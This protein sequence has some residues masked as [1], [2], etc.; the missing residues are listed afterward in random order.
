LVRYWA[1]HQPEEASRWA[2]TE[3]P[4]VYRAAA[5]YSALSVW[6]EANP[7]VAVDRTWRWGGFPDLQLIVPIALVRGWYARNDPPELREFLRSLLPDVLG[8]RA[9]GAYVR[10]LMQ[11]KGFGAVKRWAESLPA[12][13]EN[14]KVYK[15]TVFRRVVDAVSRTDVEEAKRWCDAHC[16]GPYGDTMLALIASNWAA[17]DGA[18]ALAWLE[19]RKPGYE[20]NLA[21]QLTGGS[22]DERG[23]NGGWRSRSPTLMPSSRS[24]VLRDGAPRTPSARGT[25]R[26]ESDQKR[27]VTQVDTA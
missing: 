20:T 4:P 2:A 15:L 14:D 7:R 17:R 18:G 13:N 23:G 3:S 27:V 16:E 25:E 24:L 1:T 10:V 12:N 19:T 26:I 5:V 22:R 8:Q 6:A 21:V 11:T 9:I